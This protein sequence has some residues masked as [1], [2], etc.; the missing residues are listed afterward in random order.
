M[1]AAQPRHDDRPRL[2]RVRDAVRERRAREAAGGAASAPGRPGRP[3]RRD[4]ALPAGALLVVPEPVEGPAEHRLPDDP[5]AGRASPTAVRPAAASAHSLAK[6]GFLPYA[7]TDFIF[8]IVADELGLVGALLRHRPV[9]RPRRRRH[10]HRPAARPTGSACSWPPASPAG[11]LVQA[12]VNIGAVVGVLPITGRAAA[13]RVV[14]RFVAAWSPWPP[15]GSQLS[16]A[17]QAR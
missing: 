5:V 13:V 4:R 16:I 8:A 11:S 2:D 7:H 17:R 1:I 6:W 10:P 15:S 14:R 12:F 3:V 9:R